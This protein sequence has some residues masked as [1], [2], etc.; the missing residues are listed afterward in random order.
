MPHRILQCHFSWSCSICLFLAHCTR[1]H[2][3]VKAATSTGTPNWCST[4]TMHQ[5]DCISLQNPFRRWD[6]ASVRV[7][8]QMLAGE[9][10]ARGMQ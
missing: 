9:G 3:S 5:V 8:T 4:A 2:F 10:D 6:G 1:C 7:L